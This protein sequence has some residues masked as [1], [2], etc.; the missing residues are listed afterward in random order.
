LSG[1]D[2]AIRVEGKVYAR[3]TAGA[4]SLASVDEPANTEPGLSPL[5]GVKITVYHAEDYASKPIDKSTQYR[6][7]PGGAHQSIGRAVV[8]SEPAYRA[9]KVLRYSA[10]SARFQP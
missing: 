7:G 9:F 8:G 5:E 3:R 2:G 10:S 4:E 6:V 1:C